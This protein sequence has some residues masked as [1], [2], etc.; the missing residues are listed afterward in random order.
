[1]IVVKSPG[2]DAKAHARRAN[3]AVVDQARAVLAERNDSDP[4]KAVAVVLCA[5]IGAMS[6]AVVAF[7]I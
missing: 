3:S 6:G 1:M 7:L 2:Y 5:V 4:A